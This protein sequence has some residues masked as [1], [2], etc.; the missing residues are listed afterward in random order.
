M[1]MKLIGIIAVML[2]CTLVGM[3]FSDK[4]KA[5]VRELTN[6][7]Y[8]FEQISVLIRYKA[9][10]VYEIID[11][12]KENEIC[13]TLSFLTNFRHLEDKSFELEWIDCINSSESEL[14]LEDKRV[15][16]SFGNVFGTSDI[17]GQLADIEVFRQNFSELTNKAKEDY[18][19]KSKLYKSLGVISGAFI[20]IMLI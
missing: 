2:S 16:K 18:D 4:L 14:R 6:I 15:L 13:K 12:L 17:D 9:L 11:A 5:R 7:N 19:K 20:S 3:F 8:M 1:I 10:T